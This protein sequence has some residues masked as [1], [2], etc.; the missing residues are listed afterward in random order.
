MW[1]VIALVCLQGV[2]MWQPK[3]LDML[4]MGDMGP[5]LN[6]PWLLGGFEMVA[7]APS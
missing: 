5:R 6:D 4:A 1:N 3:V 2:E 7:Y